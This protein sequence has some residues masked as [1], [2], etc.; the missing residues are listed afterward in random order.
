MQAALW[1]IGL[2]FGALGVVIAL[3]AEAAQTQIVG[4]LLLLTGVTAV[5]FGTVVEALRRIYPAADMSIRFG[6]PASKI[7]QSARLPTKSG[8]IYVP[9]EPAFEKPTR[10]QP[11]PPAP[12]AQTESPVRE[13]PSRKAPVEKKPAKAAAITVPAAAAI[14]KPAPP[15]PALLELQQ[16]AKVSQSS[17]KFV[18]PDH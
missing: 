12:A 8:K 7:S 11:P 13:T 6:P 16:H 1:L 9:P 5:G 15:P 14:E 18:P 4:C 2:F 3:V 17:K 10:P